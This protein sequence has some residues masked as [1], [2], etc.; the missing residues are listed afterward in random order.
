MPSGK[1]NKGKDDDKGKKKKGPAKGSKHNNKNGKVIKVLLP[2]PRPGSYQ[3]GQEEE[4]SEHE[5]SYND[6]LLA[7]QLE[8]LA[9]KGLNNN[10]IIDAL[11][12]SRDTFYKRLANDP[13]FSYCLHKHRGAVV[14]QVENAMYKTATGFTYYEQ[15]ATPMGDIVTLAKFA[16]PNHAAQKTILFNKQKDEWRARVEPSI[17]KGES[18]SQLGQTVII[19]RRAD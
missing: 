12:I 7:V 18:I 4:M 3:E 5:I 17:D 16:L 10:Q 2:V 15:Q 14:K 8:E 6:A 19:K 13:Y 1:N 11:P 9:A